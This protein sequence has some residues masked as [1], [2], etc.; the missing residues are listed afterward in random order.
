MQSDTTWQG[1]R[2]P[3]ALLGAI[4]AS[5]PR[6]QN[7]TTLRGVPRAKAQ[8]PSAEDSGPA[9][10]SPAPAH[11]FAKTL[12]G[13]SLRAP[14]VLPKPTPVA[15]PTPPPPLTTVEFAPAPLAVTTPGFKRP[16]TVTDLDLGAAR[17]TDTQPRPEKAE[18][19]DYLAASPR[20]SWATWLG[21]GGL[22]GAGGGLLAWLLI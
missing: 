5:S 14:A 17:Q 1:A 6:I 19:D 18:T 3:Q 7:P 8:A 10:A 2:S 16:P 13:P 21:L 15:A 20:R 9:V 4:A 11:R 12:F 22:V